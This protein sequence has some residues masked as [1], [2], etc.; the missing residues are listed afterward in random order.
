M[1]AELQRM[2]WSTSI[3]G[4]KVY[5]VP[6]VVN[7]RDAVQHLKQFTEESQ[8]VASGDSLLDQILIDFADFSIVP[9]M[10]NYFDKSRFYRP[11]TIHLPR[12]PGFLLADEIL[13]Y[14]ESST[15]SKRIYLS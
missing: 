12:N 11:G 8:V 10:E 7:K 14:V 3:Q 2:G 13:K 1:S 15:S 5:V 4:R 9:G 6:Q